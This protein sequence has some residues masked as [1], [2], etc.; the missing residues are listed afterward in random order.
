MQK[1]RA[2][3][4]KSCRLVSGMPKVRAFKPQGIPGREL[5][6][7][8][9]GVDEMEALRLADLDGFYQQA[10]AER[11]NVSRQTFGRI[12][13]SAHRKVA[14]AI[15]HGKSIVIEGGVIMEGERKQ[16][17]EKEICACASCGHETEHTP[18][19]PCRGMTCPACGGQMIR[20]GG[21]GA[22]R[23]RAHGH[24]KS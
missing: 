9:L 19:T 22:G 12:L 13:D 23:R 7:V 11:M 24:Q 18:G 8:V 3:R 16:S 6:E 15:I 4:P 10:A 1:N 20:K 21:C 14:E 5:Q 2:G 17:D